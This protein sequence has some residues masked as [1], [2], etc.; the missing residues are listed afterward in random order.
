MAVSGSP[1]IVPGLRDFVQR[2]LAAWNGCDTDAMAQLITDD[3]VWVDPAVP[4]P[5]RGVGGGSG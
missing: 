1:P 4:E 2:Y 5:G 3:I